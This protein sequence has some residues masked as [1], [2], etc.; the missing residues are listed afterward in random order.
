MLVIYCDNTAIDI[1][2][3]ISLS[4]CMKSP[5]FNE[6]D[7]SSIFNFQIPATNKNKLLFGWPHR[8]NNT[9]A[10]AEKNASIY[11]SGQLLCQG[12]MKV[13]RAN[14]KEYECS[15]G[16]GRGELFYEYGDD[17]LADVL[18]DDNHTVGEVQEIT[19]PVS[20]IVH[21]CAVI[22]GFDELVTKEY[23]DTNY[24]VFPLRIEDMCSSM[25]EAFDNT[26][27]NT[28]PVVNCWDL[29]EQAFMVP[30]LLGNEF[31]EI[32]VVADEEN[33]INYLTYLLPYNIFIPF[34]YNSWV[35][36]NLFDQLG[37]LMESNPFNKDE[38]LKKLIV[39]NIQSLNRVENTNEGPWVVHVTD[40][41]DYIQVTY[42]YLYALEPNISFNLKDHVPGITVWEYIRAL[43]NKFFV[44]FFLDNRSKTINIR[45]LKDIINSN[46]FDDYSENV[47]S[48]MDIEFEVEK[49]GKL[50]EEFDTNDG[51]SSFIHT[52]AEIDEF[53]AIA[54]VE[55]EEDLPFNPYGDYENMIAYASV[56]KKYFVGSTIADDFN[57]TGT[58]DLYAFE[59]YSEIPV[60]D[61][62][63]EWTTKAS[64]IACSHFK[65][66]KP[67]TSFIKYLWSL[68][69]T[70]QG[71]KFYDAHQTEE[72]DCGLRFLFYRGLQDGSMETYE[73]QTK[74][75]IWSYLID[76]A[77]SWL[78]TYTF[79]VEEDINEI[80]DYIIENT[81]TYA[82]CETKLYEFFDSGDP[83]DVNLV[84]TFLDYFVHE[85]DIPVL[86]STET[87][88]YPLGT[89]DVY[90][91]NLVKIEAAN[92]SLKWDGDYG[93]YEKLAKEWLFWYNNI[94]KKVVI[95]KILSV[96]DIINIDFS[97]KKRIKDVNYLLS[98]VT[99]TI[100]KNAISAATITAFKC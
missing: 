29:D 52:E 67:G 58:W 54:D 32:S 38:D 63:G 69:D 19:D 83:G 60:G 30:T 42:R 25:G 76:A 26:Y 85:A 79:L 28:T 8:L 11:F 23:P 78:D 65:D 77:R 14:E 88:H 75:S 6:Q 22:T 84:N 21:D 18:P 47:L 82:E 61:G 17:Q 41:E 34:P 66:Y 87:K 9:E 90:D 44:R 48:V 20:G 68:G 5:L 16:I 91:A 64:A 95:N 96:S 24:A 73:T 40:P 49:I 39:Y 57:H 43:E 33:H 36:D 71:I 93:I 37:Y 50:I 45:F 27:Y 1:F 59:H 62:E 55:Y 81:H 15:V 94:A 86:I 89:N 80:V 99:F 97:R 46:D 10:P 74:A 100:T 92:L 72:N 7:G 35:I 31:F 13:I 70:K 56:P 51:N 53:T 4:V 3:D 2:D 12:I 98:E